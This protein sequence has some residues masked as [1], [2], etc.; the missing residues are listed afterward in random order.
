MKSFHLRW[1]SHLPNMGTV[2]ASLYQVLFFNTFSAFCSQITSPELFC[3]SLR[4]C[5]SNI[6]AQMDIKE[7]IF[8]LKTWN[9]QTEGLS[10]V[11]L[12][13]CDGSLRAH[14][15]ILSTCSDYFLVTFTYLFPSPSVSF[16]D[17]S[18][19]PKIKWKLKVKFC[20]PF[21]NQ[22]KYSQLFNRTLHRGQCCHNSKGDQAFT[23]QSCTK[24]K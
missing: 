4:T 1:A 5:L 21:Y 9:S 11:C 2:F 13:C 6:R 7:S 16:L 8:C 3:R 14:K 10:D 18:G 19:P 24:G 20:E 23:I 22:R 17:K 15:L 12:S